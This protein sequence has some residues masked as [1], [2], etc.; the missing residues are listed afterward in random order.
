MACGQL[1]VGGCWLP[2]GHTGRC[3]NPDTAKRVLDIASDAIE[4]YRTALP[5]E[6][7]ADQILNTVGDPRS[8][9]DMSWAMSQAR[10]IVASLSVYLPRRE[11]S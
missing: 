2:V 11:E 5:L 7:S 1:P 10:D 6:G 4:M 8:R 9:D 3:V